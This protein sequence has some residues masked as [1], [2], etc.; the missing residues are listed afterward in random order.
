MTGLETKRLLPSLPTSSP[1]KRVRK[2]VVRRPPQIQIELGSESSRNDSEAGPLPQ[3]DESE[4]QV[5]EVLPQ[6]VLH[7]G[8]PNANPYQPFPPHQLHTQ[9][10]TEHYQHYTFTRN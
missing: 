8:F 1:V 3:T 5:V 2:S 6:D 4:S 10:S 9:W 7:L